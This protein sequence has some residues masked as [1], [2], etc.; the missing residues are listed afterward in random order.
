MRDLRRVITKLATLEQILHISRI[1]PGVSNLILTT[2]VKVLLHS[3]A[4]CINSVLL[5]HRCYVLTLLS[6]CNTTIKVALHSTS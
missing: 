4:V 3:L 6:Q 5:L 2:S 1:R